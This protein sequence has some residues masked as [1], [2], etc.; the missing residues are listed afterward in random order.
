[1]DVVDSLSFKP[2]G[3][4]TCDFWAENAKNKCKDQK[5]KQIVN[6]TS[7]GE[8]K[9]C[10]S[11]GLNAKGA[12]GKTAEGATERVRK[13]GFSGLMCDFWREN[14][15]DSLMAARFDASYGWNIRKYL[16]SEAQSGD[17]RQGVSWTCWSE[18]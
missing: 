8:R 10:K 14:K 4:L 2:F 6:S 11:K 17:S 18:Y 5:K 16:A 3:G 9:K 7:S 15:L 12:E 13:G 1:V